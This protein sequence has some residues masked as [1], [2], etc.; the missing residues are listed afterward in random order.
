MIRACLLIGLAALAIALG[1][2][3]GEEEP[4]GLDAALAYVPAD[5][6]VVAVLDTDL[7]GEQVRALDEGAG[8]A[9]LGRPV[10]ELLRG[11]IGAQEG[12]PPADEVLELLGEDLVFYAARGAVAASIP[13]DDAAEPSFGFVLD[14]GDAQGLR[15]A[16][17]AFAELRPAGE[18]DGADLYRPADGDE[19]A[20]VALDEGVLVAASREGELRDALAR[21]ESGAGLDRVRFEALASELPGQALLRVAGDPREAL[22]TSQARRFAA[23]P[24]VGALRTVGA[25]MRFEPDGVVLDAVL[26]TDPQALSQADLPLSPGED[27]PPVVERDGAVV[28]ASSDQSQTTMFLLRLVRA[29]FPDSRFVRDLATVERGLDIDFEQ[30]F[31]RQ[32]DQP[33]LSVL[34]GQ[35][36]FAA[37][38]GVADPRRMRSVLERLAPNLGRLVQ[39]LEPLREEGLALLLL[40]A[41]DAPAPLE[42]LEEGRVRVRPIDG[43]RDLYRITGLVG[44]GPDQAV[45]GMLGDVFVV[46][47]DL[48]RARAVAAARPDVDV[49]LPGAS[50]SRGDVASFEGA[51]T[52]VLG[53]GLPTSPF[54]RFESALSATTERL[55]GTL[56]LSLAER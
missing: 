36:R 6:S 54:E 8:R 56:R 39:D 10:R 20:I 51:V 37:R 28:G 15:D 35:G 44:D 30:E 2:C 55:R 18:A 13:G 33:S 29:G 50:V 45:F 25:S 21:R 31:L 46:A 1:G 14:T 42:G 38:S 26:N 27:A 53:L 34:E 48:G 47:S 12:L 17:E 7:D 32:F 9:L 41:P 16:I 49:G 4:G 40:F 19:G 24:W 22:G 3:G 11:A 23:L 52:T 5:A 43:E